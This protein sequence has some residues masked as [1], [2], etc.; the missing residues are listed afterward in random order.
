[1][2]FTPPESFNIADHFL[3]ARL[4]EG[5]SDR[6]ALHLPAGQR[7]YGEVDVLANRYGNALL[8]LGVRQEERV[9]LALPDGEDFV[10][11]FFGALKLGAVVVMVNP[12]LPREQLRAMVGYTRAPVAVVA[13]DVAT[14]FEAA[15][16][17]A[18]RPLTLLEVEVDSGRG[19]EPLDGGQA[20]FEPR[21]HAD[22][23]DTVPAHRDD[24][25]IWLFSGGTTGAPKAVVQTHRSFANTTEL[26]AKRALGYREDDVTISV[27]KLFFGYAT[28]SNLLFPFSVGASCVLFPGHPTPPVLFD[29]IERH[30]PTIMVNVPSMI[31]KMVDDPTAPERDLSSLR[32]TTSA[33]EALAPSLYERWRERFGVELLDGLG[34]AEMWHIFVSNLPGSVRPGTLGREVEGFE[35]RVRDESGVEVRTGEVGRLWVRGDSRAIGYWQNMEETTAAFH[36]EWFVGGDLVSADEDGY[37]TYVGR[38]DDAMKVKG[39]WLLPAEVEDVLLE[40][41]AVKEA[42]VIGVDDRDGLTRPVAFVVV[43]GEHEDLDEGLKRLV[44]SRLEAYKHPREVHLVDELPRT[45]LGKVDRGALRDAAG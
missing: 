18:G 6:V 37:I 39:K 4:E 20:R 28:G 38:G 5:R 16:V 13:R 40:H 24:P 26:Y 14:A 9:L 21:E 7:T 30:H 3:T 41:E 17:G 22:D 29:L 15:A 19:D 43:E 31:A 2:T 36:G 25:A 27:P 34:T 1:M 23:L 32:F 12:G 10:G 35:V 45:H 8:A 42:A 33:G 44:L 11:A